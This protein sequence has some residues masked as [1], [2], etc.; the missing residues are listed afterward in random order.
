MENSKFIDKNGHFL[1]GY[2]NDKEKMVDTIK[3]WYR[4]KLSVLYN[5]FDKNL[6]K[7]PYLNHL[8]AYFVH[9]RAYFSHHIYRFI[10]CIVWF[11]SFQISLIVSFLSS[12]DKKFQCPFKTIRPIN[13]L[14]QEFAGWMTI[15]RR[16]LYNLNYLARYCEKELLPAHIR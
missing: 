1:Y 6:T 2:K 7:W 14:P 10:Y 9:F 5:I 13:R 4:W 12:L 15:T 8:G 16:P 3:K 11:L